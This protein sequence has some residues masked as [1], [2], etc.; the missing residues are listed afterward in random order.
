MNQNED[1]KVT[2]I[3]DEIIENGIKSKS[4]SL[5]QLQREFNYIQ[6]ERLLKRMLEKG[7]ISEVEFNK[8]T[9]LNRQTFSPVLAKIMP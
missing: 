8:I 4:V 7:L 6:A 5:E 1:K 3:T 2:K 9:A